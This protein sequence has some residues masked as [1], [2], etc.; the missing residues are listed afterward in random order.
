MKK[1]LI[2]AG[3]V[4]VAIGVFF[5]IED[6][7]EN[8]PEA[9]KTDKFIVVNPIDLSQIASISQ[10]RSCIG[11]DYSGK[12][13]EGVKET[14]RSMKHY[15][16]PI[17]ELE[18]STGKVIAI[19]P[20]DGKI[21]SIEDGENPRG[22]QVWLS[23]SSSGSWN[24]IFFHIDLLPELRKGSEVGSGQLI[25]YADLEGGANFDFALKKVGF[26]GQTLDSPFLYMAD[27]VMAEYEAVGVTPENIVILKEQRDANPCNFGVG[28]GQ[29]EQVFL[30]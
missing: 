17:P 7:T 19:A 21:S 3:I 5:F 25:G 9:V 1:V 20:F 15:L 26:G 6:G 12:N 27:E 13:T 29:D 8:G 2:I 11:H 30:K 24:F 4:A 18:Q 14:N 28:S 23:S 22:D 10:F 16:A